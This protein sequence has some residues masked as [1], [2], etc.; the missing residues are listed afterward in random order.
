MFIINYASAQEGLQHYHHDAS[1]GD[2]SP[3]RKKFMN[4]PIGPIYA[5]GDV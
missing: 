2:G 4:S 3:G 5:T 1:S